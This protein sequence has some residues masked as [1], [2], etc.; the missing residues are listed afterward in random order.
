MEVSMSRILVGFAFIAPFVFGIFFGSETT[1][2]MI[3]AATIA[4]GFVGVALIIVGF[5]RKLA[6]VSRPTTLR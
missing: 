6:V 2:P 1:P 3:V 5:N 4:A